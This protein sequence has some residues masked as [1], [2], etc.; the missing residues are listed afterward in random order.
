MALLT[1]LLF[2]F[3]YF[4]LPFCTFSGPLFY[5]STCQTPPAPSPRAFPSIWHAFLQLSTWLAPSYSWGVYLNVTFSWKPSLTTLFEIATPRHVRASHLLFYFSQ[6]HL[7]PSNILSILFVLF[8]VYL[9][10]LKRHLH[11]SKDFCLFYSLLC[12]PHLVQPRSRCLINICQMNKWMNDLRWKV[13][14]ALAGHVSFEALF[15]QQMP[16]LPDP[17]SPLCWHPFHFMAGWTRKGWNAGPGESLIWTHRG[18][19]HTTAFQP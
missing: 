14:L 3:I 2:R 8:I 11:E 16:G 7:L 17:I 13:R 1:F 18:L 19:R 9:P 5:I 10:S 4:S 12:P 15:Q 6:E